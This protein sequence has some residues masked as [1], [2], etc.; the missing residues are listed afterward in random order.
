MLRIDLLPTIQVSDGAIGAV[1]LRSIVV[2]DE[3]MALVVEVSQP[4]RKK[5][6]QLTFEVEIDLARRREY[7][8]IDRRY[9]LEKVIASAR[10]A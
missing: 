7:G 9:R 8:L 4:Q 10:P 1:L 2:L 6:V 3:T 5:I